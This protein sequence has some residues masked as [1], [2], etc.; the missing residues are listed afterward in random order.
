MLFQDPEFFKELISM[1][2]MET[3]EHI[4]TIHAG[5]DSLA[6]NATGADR[7]NTIEEVFRS[8]HSLKGAART[9]GLVD[10][11]SAGKQL[12]YFFSLIKN[13][14]MELNSELTSLF[15][16]IVDKLGSLIST[17]NDQGEIS[18]STVEVIQQLAVIEQKLNA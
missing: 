17:L 10:I 15:H 7:H 14:Q 1:F 5:L 2:K 11:E 12:E 13:D 18:G 4:K 9:V 6:G 8:A 16:D 3:D